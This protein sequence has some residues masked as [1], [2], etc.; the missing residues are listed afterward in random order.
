MK[1]MGVLSLILL[2][3][4]IGSGFCM[5]YGGNVDPSRHMLL[6]LFAVAFTAF[7]LIWAMVKVSRKDSR[8]SAGAGN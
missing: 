7:T 6:G 8:R 5:A 1:L 2:L 3:I 4:E